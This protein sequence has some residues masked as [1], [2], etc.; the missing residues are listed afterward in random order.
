MAF[1]DQYDI[2]TNEQLRI[3]QREGWIHI[4]DYFIGTNID[5]FIGVV[6]PVGCGKSGLIAITPYALQAHRVLVIS[7]GTRIRDQLGEDM[8]SSS[9]NNFYEKCSILNPDA[10]FPETVIV[11]SGIVNHDDIENADIVV[12]NIHQIAGE[13][14]RWLDEF[15]DDFFDTILVDEGHHNPATSWRQVFDRF[16]NARVI[17]FMQLQAVLMAN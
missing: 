6:L 5:R 3:P 8:K 2:E 7:P 16:P 15:G 13:E 10:E 14:N 1:T 12:S 17:N 11:A 9:E 4:R